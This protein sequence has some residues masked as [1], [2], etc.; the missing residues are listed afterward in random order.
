M[1]NPA[2][3]FSNFTTADVSSDS[4]VSPASPSWALS[5]IV[6]QPACA[7][8]ISSSGLVPMPSAK[9][10][11]NEYCVSFRTP[12]CVEIV[13]LPSFKPPSHTA[14]ALRS[15]N[16]SSLL[17]N[18]S[19]RI[20]D[21]ISRCDTKTLVCRI[22][23]NQCRS[24]SRICK[25]GTFDLI[26]I[27]AHPWGAVSYSGATRGAIPHFRRIAHSACSNQC[28]GGASLRLLSQLLAP[29]PRTPLQAH[30]RPLR[31]LSELCRLLLSAE[32]SN[33]ISKP[34]FMRST[35]CR[36]PS[37]RE[38]SAASSRTAPTTHSWGS[39]PL[40]AAGSRKNSLTDRKSV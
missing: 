40:L 33:R 3:V 13:P 21:K 4:A 15:I 29:P 23:N 18:Q 24:R 9:R 35:S 14:L 34:P 22:E 27:S 38:P 12:L 2:S 30:L 1:V 8:A 19:G 37:G 16:S 32:P 6:K 7:A 36:I 20:K 26:T 11:L 17:G 5:A 31:L 28:G 10:V 39:P 25:P